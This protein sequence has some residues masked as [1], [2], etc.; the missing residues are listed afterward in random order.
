M[1]DLHSAI[2]GPHAPIPV[3]PL[4]TILSEV[5]LKH[6][7]DV[8]R[9]LS[10]SHKPDLAR[11]RQEYCYRALSETT[12]G[13]RVIGR[14][15]QRDHSTVCWSAG[16]YALDN[17]LPF[18]RGRDITHWKSWQKRGYRTAAVAPKLRSPMGREAA[19]VPL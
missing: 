2:N 18:A 9:L 19:G 1:S 7:V 8:D 10:N 12:R 16:I 3:G 4:R 14:V 11:C 17:G 13:G 6:G 15:I 5:V